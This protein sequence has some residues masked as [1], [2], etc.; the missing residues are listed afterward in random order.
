M[1]ISLALREKNGPLTA[2]LFRF[3]SDII[4]AVN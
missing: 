3:P 2:T 1:F 4:S